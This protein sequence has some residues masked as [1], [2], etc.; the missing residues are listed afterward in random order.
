[1]CDGF[2]GVLK[3]S[4]IAGLGTALLRDKITIDKGFDIFNKYV[5]NWGSDMTVYRFDAM[6][7]A[8]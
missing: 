3:P 1:M 6:K 4:I 2:G 7:M 8:R 5:G